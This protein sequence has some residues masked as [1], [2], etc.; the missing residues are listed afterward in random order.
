MNSRYHRSLSQC[1]LLLEVIGSSFSVVSFRDEVRF[2]PHLLS[3]VLRD[4]SDG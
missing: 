2:F 3:N 1:R 4:E